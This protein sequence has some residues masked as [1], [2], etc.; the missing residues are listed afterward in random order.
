MKRGLRVLQLCLLA[1]VL[2]GLF[3]IVRQTKGEQTSS[4]SNTQAAQIAGLPDRA[5][6]AASTPESAQ[7][8]QEAPEAPLSAEE[9]LA[10]IDLQA[11]R[12][13]NPDVVGWIALPGTEISYPVVQGTDNDYYLAHTWDGEN[14]SCGAIFLDCGASADFYHTSYN[15]IKNE[16]F[17]GNWYEPD[18][19][20]G[21]AYILYSAPGRPTPWASYT[22]KTWK[23]GRTPSFRTAWRA[24]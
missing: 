20:A 9:T 6:P 24:L 8:S 17:D 7:P 5:L 23:A 22:R 3:L 13:V 19:A 16:P 12:E 21:T 4:Q 10:Q 1:V 18:A 14:S 11:L 15:L 2:I